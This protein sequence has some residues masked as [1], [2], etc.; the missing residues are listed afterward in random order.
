[1]ILVIQY[2]VLHTEAVP[3]VLVL[4][5]PSTVLHRNFREKQKQTPASKVPKTH[6]SKKL[7]ITTFVK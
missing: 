2:H 5:Y 3:S 6:T 7:R 4:L 1:M